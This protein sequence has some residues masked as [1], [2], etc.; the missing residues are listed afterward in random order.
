MLVPITIDAKE[1]G[2]MFGIS[3]FELHEFAQ[4][5][6]SALAL[7]FRYEWEEQTKILK[8]SRREYKEAIYYRKLDD[9][10]YE[11]GLLG[12]L[13]NAIEQGQDPFDQKEG[14]ERSH[15]RKEKEGGGWYMTIPFRHAS[16][17]SLGESAIFSGK[18][19]PKVI[20]DLTKSSTV[21]LSVD[22]LPKEFR[23]LGIRKEVK[24]D[25]KVFED[26]E[27]KAPKYAGLKRYDIGAPGENRGGYMTFRRV[28]DTSD[29]NSWIHP[30]I[31][32]YNL[33]QKALD[34]LDVETIVDNIA[35]NLLNK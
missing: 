15:K 10:S 34:V 19:L 1:F 26:Y 35:N 23:I 16:S 17:G 7:E 6:I 30:G 8:S 20:Q 9:L 29:Y 24:V 3:E 2:E 25:G 4:N 5:T 32:E 22:D 18:P 11:V 27:H 33:A 28:S 13:P 21:P 31:K 12:W 14:F